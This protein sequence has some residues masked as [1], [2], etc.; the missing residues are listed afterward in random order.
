MN[1]NE[2][3][4]GGPGPSRPWRIRGYAERVSSSAKLGWTVRA[5]AVERGMQLIGGIR[6]L[7]DHTGMR[8]DALDGFPGGQFSREKALHASADEEAFFVLQVQ[9]GQY[10]EI[11]GGPVVHVS[12]VGNPA[13]LS[14]RIS[15]RI[16]D[17]CDR[18]VLGRGKW[19]CAVQKWLREDLFQTF[20][21]RSGSSLVPYS[22]QPGII[23]GKVNDVDRAEDH[24][25]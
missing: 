23:G 7:V 21:A 19:G 14:M 12:M 16:R 1:G 11:A 10:G 6:I 5:G 18:E 17:I 22:G 15:C 13:V 25:A 9:A 4:A 8:T 24:S 3:E 20:R 2:I